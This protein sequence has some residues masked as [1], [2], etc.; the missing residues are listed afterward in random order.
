[1]GGVFVEV[2]VCK[3]QS[4]CVNPGEENLAGTGP[5]KVTWGCRQDN[6]VV[7][8]NKSKNWLL[9]CSQSR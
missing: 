2:F 9:L 5:C 4:V 8:S 7:K 6:I 1:M 3:V